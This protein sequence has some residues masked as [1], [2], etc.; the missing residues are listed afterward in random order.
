MR[1]LVLS[2]ITLAAVSVFPQ[3]ALAAPAAPAAPA[4]SA[5]PATPTAQVD[6]PTG[7]Q[8]RAAIL[9]AIDGL[10]KLQAPSGRWPDYAQEGGVTALV[11]YAL[12]VAGVAPDD[13][14][15][16]TALPSLRRV[17]NENTYV[18]ALK[19]MAFSAADPK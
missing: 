2:A 10:R 11:T 1:A 9:R 14:A 13:R 4:A 12:L 5:T 8:V 19:A 7:R 6:A 15:M 3:N 16:E 17:E 18:V